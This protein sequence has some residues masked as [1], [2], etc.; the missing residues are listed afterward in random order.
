MRKYDEEAKIERVKDKFNIYFNFDGDLPDQ[1]FA[2]LIADY[3]IINHYRYEI[4]EPT[5]HLNLK[6][7]ELSSDIRLLLLYNRRDN[8]N[9]N[10]LQLVRIK[11]ISNIEM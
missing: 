10:K 11:L 3:D 6:F 9:N 8:G 7:E 1:V 4:T 5:K 2:D